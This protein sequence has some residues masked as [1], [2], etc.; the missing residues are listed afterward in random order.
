MSFGFPSLVASL[1]LVLLF[2]STADLFYFE[3]KYT[4]AAA[5]KEL[6]PT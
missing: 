3:D 4:V 2:V 1:T 5:V 6:L